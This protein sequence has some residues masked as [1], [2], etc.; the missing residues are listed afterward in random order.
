MRTDAVAIVCSRAHSSRVPHKAF[1]RLA[2]VPAIR[3]LLVRLAGLDF[4]TILAVPGIDYEIYSKVS[5][6][7]PHV[8]VMTGNAD[9]PLHRMAEVVKALPE[10]PKWI[11]RITHDDILQDS[12]SILE[13]LKICEQ[14]S[15]SYGNMPDIVRGA[16]AEVISTE[17]L[18]SAAERIKQPVEFVS[19]FVQDGNTCK[20]EARESVSRGYNLSLDY[21]E[22]AIILEAVLRHSCCPLESLDHIVKYI[23]DNPHLTD[24]NRKPN[25][26]FYTCA[27]NA[28]KTIEQTIRSVL[29]NP[30]KN[31]EYIIIDDCS[32]D[33]TL[34][35]IAQYSYDKRIRLHVNESNL[36]LASSSNIAVNLA[37]ADKVMRVDA[38]DVLITHNLGHH[39]AEMERLIDYGVGVIYPAYETV[40]E[41]GKR[42][43]SFN[44]PE[45]FNHAGCAMMSKRLLNEIRFKEGLRDWD[46]LEL[47]NRF[48]K[49]SPAAVRYYANPTWKYR[50][51]NDSM[52]RINLGV[53]EAVKPK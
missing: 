52:S 26:S 49:A 29:W 38:D 7:L 8:T 21:P 39:M 4:K 47:F 23:D 27:Y 44:S 35:V 16:D 18:L 10:L 48:M 30:S 19:Y 46:S 50:I 24:I 37:K 5:D 6:G 12:R 13:L 40:D 1:K 25:I 34:E 43:E 3:H 15:A 32:K 36:G 2:G 20:L 41:D 51:R 9:S 22:D 53:R 45:K 31:I 28:E 33:R 11:V 17:N 14:T 42:L